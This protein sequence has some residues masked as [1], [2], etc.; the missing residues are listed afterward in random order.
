MPVVADVHF[1]GR[2]AVAAIEAGCHKVRINP[3]NLQN[4]ETL[5][6]IVRAARERSVPIRIGL[7]A[8]S[9]VPRRGIQPEKADAMELMLKS[10]AAAV[11][12]LTDLGFDDI[13]LS[14]KCHDVRS[15][16]ATYRALAKAFPYPLHLGVTA[17]GLLRQAVIKHALAFGVLL[18]EGIGDTIRISI[19][20]DP[21]EEVR[22]AWDMLRSLHLR[23]RGAAIVACP[24]CARTAV[25][26]PAI[27]SDVEEMLEDLAAEIGENAWP[28]DVRT[29]AV[30]GCIVNGPGEAA[31]ADVGIAFEKKTA[32]IFRGGKVQERLSALKAVCRLRRIISEATRGRA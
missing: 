1:D 17:A 5:P 6:D 31:A 12:Q 3:G 20:D 7:N 14:A 25:G 13:V 19:T 26:L 11:R 9:V 30:M 22:A 27:V 28:D 2:L 32:V 23:K 4:P 15:T 8:G 29:V 16:I 10:T 24:T 21:V 18:S